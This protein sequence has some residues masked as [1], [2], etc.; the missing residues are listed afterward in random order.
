MRLASGAVAAG[1]DGSAS[2]ISVFAWDGPGLSAGGELSAVWCSLALQMRV[3][4]LN[5]KTQE[6]VD[7]DMRFCSHSRI[8]L[9]FALSSATESLHV[10][11]WAEDGLMF[12]CT[13]AFV[14]H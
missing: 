5:S 8:L 12:Q 11:V 13:A 4:K 14:E 1:A 3:A 6:T 2:T 9:G 7:F 10:S